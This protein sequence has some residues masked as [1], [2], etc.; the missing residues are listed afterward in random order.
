VDVDV[1]VDV[2]LEA[3]RDTGIR[4]SVGLVGEWEIRQITSRPEG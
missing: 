3:D 1:D 4:W 2:D